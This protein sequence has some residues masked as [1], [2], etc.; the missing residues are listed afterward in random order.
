MIRSGAGA[1]GDG[2]K[3]CASAERAGEGASPEAMARS[4]GDGSWCLY[5]TVSPVSVNE[6]KCSSS[7]L[8]IHLSARDEASGEKVVAVT[9]KAESFAAAET[10]GGLKYGTPVWLLIRLRRSLI[11]CPDLFRHPEV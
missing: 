7:Q 8:S 2:T 3:E 6:I 11:E 9:V 1:G 4:A 5:V 10:I